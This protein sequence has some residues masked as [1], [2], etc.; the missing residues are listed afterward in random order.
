MAA[1]RRGA[2]HPADGAAVLLAAQA[3]AAALAGA[4]IPLP[5]PKP[6]AAPSGTAPWAAL[7]DVGDLAGVPACLGAWGHGHVAIG[8]TLP[9]AD[10]GHGPPPVLLLAPDEAAYRRLCRLLSWHHEAPDEWAAWVVG[11]TE[12]GP[13]WDGLIALVQDVKLGGAA[14]LA[15]GGG[16]LASAGTPSAGWLDRGRRPYPDRHQRQRHEGEPHPA[17]DSRPIPGRRPHRGSARAG[18][19]MHPQGPAQSDGGNRR[20]GHCR[21]GHAL[22]AR[23]LFSPGRPDAN[24]YPRWKMPPNRVGGSRAGTAAAMP[25]RPPPALRRSPAAGPTRSSGIRTRHH[26]AEEFLLSTSSL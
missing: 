2:N 12:A 23:C 5:P 14:A 19:A 24:G 17:Y 20:P 22:A 21:R 10:D 26:H 25:G 4:T 16:P 3:S 11:L 13:A 18:G 8:A 15:W 7:A 9:L 1:D 6:A